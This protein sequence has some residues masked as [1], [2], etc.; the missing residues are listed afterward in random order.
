MSNG[1]VIGGNP[2]KRSESVVFAQK[3]V[4]TQPLHTQIN[5]PLIPTCPKV[6]ICYNGFK[7][8]QIAIH[9]HEIHKNN[10]KI[11]TSGRCNMKKL[12]TTLVAIF[13]PFAH[14]AG[15]GGKAGPPKE[16][17]GPQ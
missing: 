8:F 2:G 4:F 3:K 14:L 10:T 9:A 16:T 1:G 13:N 6:T 5:I 17:E 11:Q 12:Q 15:G 7:V